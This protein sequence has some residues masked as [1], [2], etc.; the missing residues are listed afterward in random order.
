MVFILGLFL[1]VGIGLIIGGVCLAFGTWRFIRRSVIIS[2]V[3]IRMEGYKVQAPI[4]QFTTQEGEVITFTHPVAS[5]PPSYHAG[6]AIKVRY[7]PSRPH[8]AQI[9]SF[10]SLW[11][12]PLAM[13]FIGSV[14]TVLI[15][16]IWLGIVTGSGVQANN[17]TPPATPRPTDPPTP[18]NT[19]LTQEAVPERDDDWLREIGGVPE[20]DGTTL[21]RQLGP[22]QTLL[23]IGGR[24][25]F[26]EVFCGT[27]LAMLC[28][29]IHEVATTS[30]TVEL[31]ALIPRQNYL[32]LSETLSPAEIL[33]LKTPSFWRPPMCG[34]GCQ[35]VNVFVLRDGQL[36]EMFE[37]NRP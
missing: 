7:Q 5:K 32:A 20:G 22:G 11:I 34:Q 4:V 10:A 8:A 27:D 13:F 3:V 28:V 9:N 30:Q 6:Q 36:M 15:G 24:L 29:L 23:F 25:Q 26:G 1:M 12:M 37:L 16:F 35:R 18:I 21:I 2:G 33:Q 19:P 17:S 31:E 14:A